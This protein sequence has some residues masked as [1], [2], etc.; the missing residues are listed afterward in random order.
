M[1]KENKKYKIQK[2]EF[3]I[4]QFK[5]R[6]IEPNK[7]ITD[8][9]LEIFMFYV[10]NTPCTNLSPSSIGLK[11]HISRSKFKSLFYKVANLKRNTTLFTAKKLD[12]IKDACE[13]S[14]LKNDFYNHRDIEKI[15]IYVGSNQNEITSICYHIRNSFAHGR[16][17]IYNT[18]DN[19]PVFILEDCRKM[20]DKHH[21][22]AR[23]ILKQSTLLEWIK[24]FKTVQEI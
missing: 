12:E 14:K 21:V 1:N 8:K 11:K 5:P 18:T 4:V 24:M 22:R 13:K 6:W 9:L 15:L 19:N 2:S 16:F 10:I 20:K 23:M 7:I 3:E 17:T